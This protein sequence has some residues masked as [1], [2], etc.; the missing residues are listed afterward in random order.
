MRCLKYVIITILFMVSFPMITKADC[1]YE[2]Q[3]ELSR[4]AGNV[5]FSYGYEITNENEPVFTV[6]VINVTGDIYVRDA[7]TEKIVTTSEG[8]FTY[9]NVGG[10]INYD[11]Y[12]N[13]ANCRG[14][15]IMRQSVTLPP[16]NKYSQNED[17]TLHRE[18]K[19]CQPWIDTSGVS[20]ETFD[21]GL[22]GYVY[23]MSSD[24]DATGKIDVS[25]WFEQYM[26]LIVVCIGGLILLPI[27]IFIR[28]KILI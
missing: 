20:E 8:T 4:I 28:R 7:L 11:I 15:K 18:Y 24:I 25:E 23:G 13:D 17:C 12:S 6:T 19:Y 1:S 27:L 9:S 3:A 5:G 2:R 10:S 14:E 21:E 16:Y 26:P 22:Y